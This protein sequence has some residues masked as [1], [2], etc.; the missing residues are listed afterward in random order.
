MRGSHLAQRILKYE[1]SLTFFSRT[2]AQNQL[3][4]LR[5]Q[6]KKSLCNQLSVIKYDVLWKGFYIKTNSTL[7]IEQQLGQNVSKKK[8]KKINLIGLIKD[9]HGH[10]AIMAQNTTLLIYIN[11]TTFSELS[12]DD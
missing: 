4:S 8:R 11:L 10:R 6:G 2:R 3:R 9:R 5:K 7:F 1:S 12:S